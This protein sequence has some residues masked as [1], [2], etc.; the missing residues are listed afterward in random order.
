MTKLILVRH[1]Q[2]EWNLANRFTGW[3]DVGLTEKGVAEAKA[4]GELLRDKGVL[5]TVSFTSLQT[6]AIKTLNLALEACDRLWIPVTKDWHLNERHY[7]GLTGLD[8][9][10]TREKHGDEQVHIWRRSYDTPPPKMERDD[11]RYAGNF[12]VYQGLSDSEIPL[13]ESLKDTVDRFVPYFE[14][15]IKPQIK[16]GK[17]VLICA[18]G[19]SLRALVKYLG[20]ISDEE[21]V[22][23][24]IPTGVP[25]VYELD[26]NLKPIKNYYLGDAE[27]V[28]KAAEAV[29][30]Q[31][32]A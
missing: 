12:R 18:H 7:G 22:K 27:E 4:A 20:D 31:G 5:P 24:N 2:S 1:G 21:I 26:D 19:N 8:K 17:Q 25:M 16:A 3:W 13:S 9:Q 28:A 23:L 11:E 6:R 10:E 29:A 30:N 32:K 15:E 14:S